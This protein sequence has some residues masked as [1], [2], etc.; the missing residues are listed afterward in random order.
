MASPVLPTDDRLWKID[1]GA[2]VV[3]QK[4]QKNIKVV[5]G[6]T[7]IFVWF[8]WLIFHV[9]QGDKRWSNKKEFKAQQ[10][11]IVRKTAPNESSNV[12]LVILPLDL[13]GFPTTVLVHF[14]Q[15][16]QGQWNNKRFG[17]SPNLERYNF[18]PSSSRR[19][20]WIKQ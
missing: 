16:E 18:I 15:N 20:Y 17:H 3:R 6:E 14:N 2:F 13:T 12:I 11:N 19:S 10:W 1:Y 8:C 9:K 7:N 4:T 5:N